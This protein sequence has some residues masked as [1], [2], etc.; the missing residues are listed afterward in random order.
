MTAGNIDR[1][2]F[3]RP[4]HLPMRYSLWSHDCLVGHTDLDISCV[5]DHLRQGFLEPTPQ[6]GRA[7]IDA[8]GVARIV[9]TKAARSEEP[10]TRTL[11]LA[12]FR[13][14]C[15]RREALNFVLRD[16]SG[17]AFDFDFI[18]IVDLQTDPDESRD[19]DEPED[20]DCDDLDADFFAE[21]EEVI[22]LHEESEQYGSNWPPRDDRWDSMP[23]LIQ[24]FLRR[25][26][27]AWEDTS[28]F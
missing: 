11:Y 7:L 16:E 1:R 25:S 13:R 5:T 23:Y 6:G 12:E 10:E 24:V 3:A 4:Q 14:A 19:D 20:V 15:D 9:G 22:A 28:S 26:E 18:R 2:I 27:Y 8:T 17:E 21:I